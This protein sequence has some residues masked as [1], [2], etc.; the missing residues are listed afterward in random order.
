MENE[1]KPIPARMKMFISVG[2]LTAILFAFN[3]CVFKPSSTVNKKAVSTSK[4]SDLP[5]APTIDAPDIGSTAV[6]PE[7][8][9]MPPMNVPVPP[10]SDMAVIQVGVKNFEQINMTMSLLTGVPTTDANILTVFN[11][12]T[13]Q[14]PSDNSVKSF[15]PS[16]Q[17]AITKLAAEY[18]DRAVETD[19]YRKVIWTTIDFNQ[20]PSQTLTPTNKISL[21][22]QSVDRF[23]GPIDASAMNSAKSELLALYDTL[24]NGESLTSN[25][26]TKKVVKGIC[27]ASLSSAYVTLL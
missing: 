13:I 16:M 25:L 12:I 18:C 8:M 9:D 17:V 23:F 19:A 3:Q 24:I 2:V 21:I 1:K 26:T 10:E 15:L 22:N 20:S 4:L 27:V 11:D 6:L 14:L 7:G 5:S